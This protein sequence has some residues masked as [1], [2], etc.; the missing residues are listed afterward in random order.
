MDRILYTTNKW[1]LTP[2]I[3]WTMDVKAFEQ[4]PL[5]RNSISTG[6]RK[7]LSISNVY[8]KNSYSSYFNYVTGIHDFAIAICIPS[9]VKII[10]PVVA[11]S[12]RPTV[13]ILGFGTPGFCLF[14]KCK[15]S[16]NGFKRHNSK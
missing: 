11:T 12:R 14:W 3:A 15:V 1:N 16:H 5:K 13:K 7:A 10:N 9:L 6:F 8:L 2:L 4:N